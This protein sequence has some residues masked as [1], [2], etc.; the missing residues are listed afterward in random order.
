MSHPTNAPEPSL[1]DLPPVPSESALK[2]R[3]IM[4][5][6]LSGLFAILPIAITVAIVGWVARQILDLVGPGTRIGTTLREVGLRFVTNTWVAQAIGWAIVLVGI[7]I[8]GLVVRT[9]A[10]A[11][12]DRAVGLVMR[13]IPFVKGIYGTATQVIGMLERRDESELSGMSVVFCDFGQ[14]HGAGLL[15]LLA[16]PE[17]FTFGGQSYHVVYMPT[18]PI[19]M[20]GGIVFVPAKSLHP[21]RMSVEKLMEIYLSLGILTPQAVP[22]GHIKASL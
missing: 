4:A 19:P 18:S 12:F 8:V 13:R 22:P 11:A 14:E 3:G 15:C 21:V 5:T 2:R 10:R 6:F 16:T 20:T 17:V 7:W 1:P 9:R